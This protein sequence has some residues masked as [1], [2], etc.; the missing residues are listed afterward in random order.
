MLLLSMCGR[1]RDKY[2]LAATFGYGPRSRPQGDRG[3]GL[4]LQLT[5]ETPHDVPIPTDAGVLTT[6]LSFGTLQAA[7]A[8]GD[9]QTL[10]EAGWRIAR[11]HVGA[12]GVER[13][14][15]FNQALV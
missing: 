8:L 14:R 9:R 11:V 7:Q 5:A 13:L 3:R 15:Q 12:Q 1:I 4:V 2:G 10:Q 6:T